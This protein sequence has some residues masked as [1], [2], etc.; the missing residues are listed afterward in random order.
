VL[1]AINSESATGS[2]PKGWPFEQ[3]F[4]LLAASPKPFFPLFLSQSRMQVS[5]KAG[6][7]VQTLQCDIPCF[8]KYR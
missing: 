8:S 4:T 6:E 2:N 5:I 7:E 3:S 1:R